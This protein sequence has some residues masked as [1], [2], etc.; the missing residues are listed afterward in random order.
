M[1]PFSVVSLFSLFQE[2][3]FSLILL[4][5]LIDDCTI[6]KCDFYFTFYVISKINNTFYST[7]KKMHVKIKE[8]TREKYHF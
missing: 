2:Q 7:I 6:F 3:G 4:Y 8:G 5:T 1:S